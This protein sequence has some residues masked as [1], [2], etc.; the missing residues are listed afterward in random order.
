LKKGHCLRE[1]FLGISLDYVLEVENLNPVETWLLEEE[2]P[3]VRYWA[4]Q[5]LKGVK[6]PDPELVKTQKAI[7]QSIPIQKILSAQNPKGFWITSD[8]IYLP[9]YQASTHS[10]L[11][12]AELGCQRI[13]AIERG[14]EQIFTCQQYSGHFRPEQPKTERAKAS[15]LSDGVCIDAN[16]LYYMIHF[17]YLEDP[18]VQQL[19]SFLCTSYSQTDFGWPCRAF[20][21]NPTKVFPTNCYMC[22]TKGLRALAQIPQAK[23]SKEISVIIKKEIEHLLSNEIYRYL[24]TPNGE[25]KVKTGWTRFGFPLFY[26]SDVLEVLDTLTSLGVVDSRMDDAIDLVVQKR[27]PDGKWSL[28]HSFNG[29]MWVDIETKKAPSKWITLR[30]WRVLH[31]L[32][33]L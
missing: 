20:P 24:K 23:R 2:N 29:K 30:A 8:N 22:S 9:K 15:T 11:I 27:G 3:S 16:I 32:N 25:R 17:G 19:L 4:L 5:Q 1:P 31:R 7:M 12:L 6:L 14:I 10:L 28:D 33:R 21:I 26:N 18:R 13:P